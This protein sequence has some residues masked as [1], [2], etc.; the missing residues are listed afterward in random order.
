MYTSEVTVD[1]GLGFGTF[2]IKFTGLII[3]LT[4]EYIMDSPLQPH[5]AFWLFAGIT[6]AGAVFMGLFM[7]ETR[8]LTDKQKKELYRPVKS[9][10]EE[11]RRLSVKTDR[12]KLYDTI[13][14]D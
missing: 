10:V 14:D 5:G 13:D 7:K 9:Y 12:M 6:W 8:G 11:V 4:T 1:T 3:S 2:G